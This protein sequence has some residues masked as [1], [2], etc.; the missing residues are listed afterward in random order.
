MGV[1]IP[2]KKRYVILEWPLNGQQ[3]ISNKKFKLRRKL[4][5]SDV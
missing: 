5:Q 3:A 2:G 4:P 1:Q